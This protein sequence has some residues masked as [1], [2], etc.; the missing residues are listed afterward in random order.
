MM[1][2]RVLPTYDPYIDRYMRM[3]ET[4]EIVSCKEQKLLMKFLR[5]KLTDPNIVI[6]HEIIEKS[7]N[8]PAKYFPFELLEWEKF[9]NAFIYG[10]RYKDSGN[11]VFDR[12]L[13]MM[14]RGAGKNGFISFNSF[15]ML[16]KNLGIP[17]YDID[18]VATS[19]DQAMRSFNDVYYVIKDNGLAEKPKN[20]QGKIIKSAPEPPFFITREMIQHKEMRS[21]L[22]YNTSNAR[23]KDSKRSGAVIF[24]EIHEYEDYANITVYRG[25]L[26][27]V[28]DPREFYL[29]TDGYIRD[30]VLDDMKFEAQ[31]VLRG[32]RPR[33]TMFPFICRIDDKKEADDPK[34]WE[35]AN[36]SIR[37]NK[38]LRREVEKAYEDSKTNGKSHVEFMAKRMNCPIE[39]TLEAVASA[40]EIYATKRPV[41]VFDNRHDAIGGVDFA[42]N[43]DFCSVGVYLKK[44]GVRYWTQHTFM[45]ADAPRLQGINQELIEEAVE[46]G[47]LTVVY[48]RTIEPE[49]VVNWFLKQ[50]EKYD[51]KKICADKYRLAVLKP[52]LEAA[53]FT[54][55][56]VRRGPE[57]HA[58]LSPLVDS[59]FAT[60]SLV[61]GDDCLM[62]WYCFNV[63]KYIK[64]NGNV[65]YK[66][67]EQKK[68]K[69][70][71]FFALLHA[72][73]MDGE[74][75][76]ATEFNPAQ[77]ETFM[78]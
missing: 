46:N 12:F 4:G 48:T 35:K 3:V 28:A 36:P 52:A 11:L 77:F 38:T 7:I 15:F 37:Y 26:G 43:R 24:D 55:E 1:A 25:G 53:G 65:E 6:N 75:D 31:C 56:V 23:T 49:N 10:V 9:I 76:E 19:E 68:R 57:T 8:V 39:N 47:L 73:N 60:Q 62:R 5:K 27:K 50:A 71:G 54:V 20:A 64:A 32:D 17:R 41:P 69:T 40:D 78:Y 18:L 74:L 63:Y 34:L 42:D 30:G 14:G 58:K 51:F 44:D 72:M 59:L 33:S 45:Q 66:K 67:Y 21:T 29:T 2:M 70:D 22:I 13:I 16:S 61:F